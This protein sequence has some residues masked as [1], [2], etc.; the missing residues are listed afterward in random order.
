MDREFWYSLNFAGFS[1]KQNALKHDND[2][3]KIKTLLAAKVLAANVLSHNKLAIFRCLD[4]PP[5]NNNKG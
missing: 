2:M 1:K 5:Q 4:R 3:C